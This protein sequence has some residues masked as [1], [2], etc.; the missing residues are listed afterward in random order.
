MRIATLRKFCEVVWVKIGGIIQ[1]EVKEKL[2][3]VGSNPKEMV[4]NPF[5][6]GINI[7]IIYRRFHHLAHVSENNFISILL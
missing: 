4:Q 2:R 1:D 7:P 5:L 6:Q 3:T